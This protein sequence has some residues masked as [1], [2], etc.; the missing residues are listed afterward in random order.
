MVPE[1][2]A[3]PGLDFDVM[4]M[5]SLGTSA[6]V[7]SLTGLCLSQPRR[8][9]PARPPT[10]WS[11]P[12]RPARSRWSS[13]RRLPPAR[14]PDGGALRR[15]P[16]ARPAAAARVGVHLQRQ[17]HAVYPP[18]IGQWDEL[19]RPCRP[20]A[21]E[22]MLHGTP[23]SQVPRLTRQ[24]DRASLRVARTAVAERRVAR[25]A[26]PRV[27]IGRSAGD[28]R[29]ARRSRRPAPARPA[30]PARPGRRSAREL[31]RDR[32]RAR[33]PAGSHITRRTVSGVTRFSAGTPCSSDSCG[34]AV[35]GERQAFGGDRVALGPG[36][37]RRR[38]VGA[39]RAHRQVV[40]GHL[41]RSTERGQPPVGVPLRR[42]GRGS[43][44]SP[45]GRARVVGVGQGGRDDR[46]VADDPARAT[47]RARGRARRGPPR[48]R[49]RRRAAGGRAPGAARTYAATAR[50]RTTGVNPRSASN[51]W[52]AHSSLPASR[53]SRGQH[54]AQLDAAPRRRARR[55]PATGSGS[56]RVDQS[57]AECSFFIR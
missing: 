50:S 35:A 39:R 10:S 4:P 25:R 40:L 21:C 48:A 54:L 55:T 33:A 27:A 11:T 20:D 32:V 38:T 28:P 2:R 16:A 53:S 42:R 31:A 17:E 56:G 47:R 52:R 43:P 13:V 7:G 18:L 30:R 36:A 34:H 12:A 51:S 37:R 5:P 45:A 8:A 9:T 26:D 24:I 46:G 57:A 23:A 22:Q 19:D 41:A 44:W 29:P 3:V 6:T 49:G 14:Q 1:L 15:L